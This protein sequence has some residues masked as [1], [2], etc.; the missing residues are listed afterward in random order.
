M[1]E[2]NGKIE[3]LEE[4]ESGICGCESYHSDYDKTVKLMCSPSYRDRFVAEYQ[5][6]KIR[7]EKLKRFVNKILASAMTPACE[8]VKHDCPLSLLERQLR[9]M[10]EYLDVLEIRAEIEKIVL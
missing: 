2:D 6:T 7:Y 1:K 9:V 3:M 5:Q 4:K 10:K 8:P